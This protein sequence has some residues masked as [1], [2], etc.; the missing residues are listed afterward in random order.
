MKNKYYNTRIIDSIPH[1]IE[2][3]DLVTDDVMAEDFFRMA[4][5][6]KIPSKYL[7]DNMP[8]IGMDMTGA[9]IARGEEKALVYRIIKEIKPKEIDE[10]PIKEIIGDAYD[11]IGTIKAIFIPSRL[12]SQVYTDFDFNF[13]SPR[14]DSVNDG[15]YQFKV[16]HST[17]S[18]DWEEIVVLGQGALEWTRKITHTLPPN[19]SNY[20]YFSEK[21][22]HLQLAYHMNLVDC[23]FMLGTVSK[24]N[25]INPEKIVTYRTPR[26]T[27]DDNTRI[28]EAP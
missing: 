3:K 1:A 21:N 9:N 10:K 14:L 26:E 25:I 20:K 28:I 27:S 24:C 18:S 11:V 17:I 13:P 16:I 7:K 8:I 23:H 6:S 19:I 12:F 2:I 15:I 4:I 22:E 5:H